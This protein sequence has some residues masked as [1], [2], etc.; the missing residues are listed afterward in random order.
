MVETYKGQPL[1]ERPSQKLGWPDYLKEVAFG[2]IPLATAAGALLF[3]K[4]T[5]QKVM[6]L[7][8]SP[9]IFTKGWLLMT[10][11]SVKAATGKT[12]DW[13]KI[14]LIPWLTLLYKNPADKL[15]VTHNYW[16]AI[17][18]FEFGA[19]PLAFHIWHKKEKQRIDL[20]S[21][22]D[23]LKKLESLKPSNEELAAEN[24]SLKQQLEF[25]HTH[26]ETKIAHHKSH[27]GTIEGHHSHALPHEGR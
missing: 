12:I 2:L 14:D 3:G 8:G 5:N 26:P 1:E 9:D 19:I 18:G 23:S 21:T 4:L 16:N 22:Y 27:E 11:K 24:A 6:P 20:T 7:D 15:R 10:K 13:D 17:K 25:V